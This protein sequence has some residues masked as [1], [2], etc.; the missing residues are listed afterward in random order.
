MNESN[1]KMKRWDAKRYDQQMPF[2][3]GQGGP[4]LD[5]LN[6]QAGEH[7]LDLGC[8][9]GDLANTLHERG[10]KVIGM[11][12]SQDMIKR[13]CAKYP[14]LTWVQGDGQDFS[15]DE[16]LDAVFSNAAL[17]WMKDA[18]AVIASV[19]QSL[20]PG[21]R[22]VAEFGGKGNVQSI[23]DIVSNVFHKRGLSVTFPWYFPSIGEYS[24]LLEEAGFTV[25]YAALFDRPQPL[26]NGSAGV[27]GWLEMFA[28][29]CFEG[30]SWQEKNALL[31]SITEQAKPSLWKEGQFVADYVRLQV[32]AYKPIGASSY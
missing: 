24:S 6:P 32:S 31:D 11:D 2:V 14:E 5:V 29:A 15:F 13:A 19:Y 7:I 25:R 9:T 16:P 20:K 4:I 27:R 30:L 28:D 17:H 22:F 1:M 10:C 18:S 8:G 21:G 12:Y 3:S 23:M 26:S